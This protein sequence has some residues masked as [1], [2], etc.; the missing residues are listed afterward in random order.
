MSLAGL[1]NGL[2]GVGEDFDV[3]YAPG[4]EKSEPHGRVGG[5]LAHRVDDGVADANQ[6][7]VELVRWGVMQRVLLG[8][9][10]EARV[11][12][13][14]RHGPPVVD[15]VRRLVAVPRVRRKQT[16]K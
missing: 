4:E 15:V 8:R 2:E 11:L 5:D 13:R 14:F 10:H 3:H 6:A 1:S 16:E 12:E 7:E 9:D